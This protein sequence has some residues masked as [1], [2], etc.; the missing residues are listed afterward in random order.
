MGD[1]YCPGHMFDNASTR[2]T[3][4]TTTKISTK[5]GTGF[6]YTLW[7]PRPEITFTLFYRLA[8][9]RVVND[10]QFAETSGQ[11]LINATY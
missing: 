7:V 3:S 8:V 4:E 2:F 9:R 11:F 6:A 10:G 5:F 1:I